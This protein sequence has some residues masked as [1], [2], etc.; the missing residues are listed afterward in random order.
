[1]W[2]EVWDGRFK[3]LM[4]QAETAVPAIVN[5][6]KNTGAA[7]RSAPPDG[8]APRRALGRDRAH[9][10]RRH[11]RDPDR[12]PPRRLRRFLFTTS[13]SAASF[14]PALPSGPPPGTSPR[15]RRS[16]ALC[17]NDAHRSQQRSWCVVILRASGY[18][19]CG[20][21]GRGRPARAAD[22]R[23]AA[24]QGG[25]PRRCSCVAEIAQVGRPGTG[26]SALPLRP[27]G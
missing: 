11:A 4:I 20:N 5:N 7:R 21:L 22:E 24:I 19:G 8:D 18:A 23:R 12:W 10:R 1:M 14:T 25:A 6:R 16:Y 2:D 17:S 13:N 26:L 3:A 9:C 15:R 27:V